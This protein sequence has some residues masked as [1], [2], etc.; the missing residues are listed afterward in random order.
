MKFQIEKFFLLA[1]PIVNIN[2]QYPD[3]I[4]YEQLRSSIEQILSNEEIIPYK[5]QFHLRIL[6]CFMCGGE[7][8]D[9]EIFFSQLASRFSLS[10]TNQYGDSSF[11]I[12]TFIGRS[13][14]K[15]ILKKKFFLNYF[16]F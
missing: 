11:I 16:F 15:V 1:I 7:T 5:K 4:P 12:N 13:N 2:F 10:V 9:I 3:N 8:N 6:L 14:R